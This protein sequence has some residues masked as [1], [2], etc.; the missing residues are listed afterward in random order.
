M[1]LASIC[2]D[3]IGVVCAGHAHDLN[4]SY[5]PVHKLGRTDAWD[6]DQS[7]NTSFINAVKEDKVAVIL[8]I[9]PGDWTFICLPGAVQRVVMNL[10]GNSLKYTRAGHIIVRLEHQQMAPA[11]RAERE[12]MS[13]AHTSMVILTVIDTGI[14]I[15]DDFLR[16]KLY[17]PFAQESTL[18]S[19]TGEF[20]VE[21]SSASND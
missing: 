10:V 3:I 11:A 2:E 18:A 9:V 21:E 13:Q 14:G 12:S 16:Y 6:R 15:S 20:S 4:S 19:G 7:V 17:T 5:H 1:D 8:E